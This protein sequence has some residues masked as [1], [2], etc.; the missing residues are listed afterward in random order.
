MRSC[1]KGLC[2]ERHAAETPGMETVPA[3]PRDPHVCGT[4]P[5][6]G[7][8]DKRGCPREAGSLWSRTGL[9][10]NLG[11]PT[12]QPSDPVGHTLPPPVSRLAH[13]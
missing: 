9:G 12:F 8:K 10:G 5:G 1:L 11:S 2:K 7:V 13:L 3:G 6:E 4:A